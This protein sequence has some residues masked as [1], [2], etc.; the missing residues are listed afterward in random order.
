MTSPAKPILE[1]NDELSR[2]L[3]YQREQLLQNSWA[4]LT[5]PEALADE[6]EQFNRVI[7]GET[8]GYTLDK[9]WIRKDCQIINSIVSAKPVRRANGSVEY[10]VKLVLDITERKSDEEKLRRNEMYLAEGQRISHTASW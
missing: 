10:L 8:D 6:V 3:R 4:E 5:H 9:R 2:I 7:T 1:V